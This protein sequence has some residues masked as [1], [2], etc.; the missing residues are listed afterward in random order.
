MQND[1][2]P[3]I[4]LIWLLI[5][6]LIS[7]CLSGCSNQKADDISSGESSD[8]E[9]SP[10]PKGHN[11]D[12]NSN[13][14]AWGRAMGSVLISIND[15][16]PYYFGGYEATEANE[17]AASGILKSSWNILGRED[18]LKQIQQ[19]LQTGSRADYRREAQEM[20]SLSKKE[21]EKAWKQ[22]PDELEIYYSDLEYNWDTWGKRGLLA[23]DFCR[24][25]HLAQWGYIAGYLNLEEAQ[26]VIEPAAIR[27]QKQFDSWEE[28]IKNWL[29]GYCLSASVPIESVEKTDYDNRMEVYETLVSEQEQRGILYDDSLFDTEIILIEGISYQSI[30]DELNTEKGQNKETLK[31]SKKEKTKRKGGE[32]TK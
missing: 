5:I 22:L 19:L 10:Y 13:L 23:W 20:N 25:S 4:L 24:I 18:L 28:V 30:M 8:I 9:S 7:G 15:G 17:K 32:D 27:L 14:G 6:S 11:E 16:N 3:N 29:D 2:K 26:A 31:N 1:F 12:E 21:R